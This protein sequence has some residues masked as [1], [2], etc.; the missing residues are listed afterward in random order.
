[1]VTIGYIRIILKKKNP[2]KQVKLMCKWHKEREKL[3]KE[4]CKE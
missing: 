1:M 2:L 4:S 3:T